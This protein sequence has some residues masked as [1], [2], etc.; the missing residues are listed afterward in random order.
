M[1]FMSEAETNWPED[2]ARQAAEYALY[3]FKEEGKDY[4]HQWLVTERRCVISNVFDEDQA[5]IERFARK[6]NELT[7]DTTGLYF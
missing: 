6:F 2:E 5:L 1:S 3:L 4:Y 7:V